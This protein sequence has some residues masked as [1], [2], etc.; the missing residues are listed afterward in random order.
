MTVLLQANPDLSMKEYFVQWN[1]SANGG[2]VDD[3]DAHIE[4][5][6]FK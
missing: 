1:I 6:G 3:D 5:L 4:F 2:K